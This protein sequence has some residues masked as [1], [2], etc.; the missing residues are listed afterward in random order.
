MRSNDYLREA[1]QWT[2][3]P[4]DCVAHAIRIAERLLEEGRAPWIGRVRD[5]QGQWHGPLIPR[6]FEGVTWTTHY[7]A[8]AGREVYDPIAGEPLDV[9]A[10]AVP[11]FG[12]PLI[13]ETHVGV[14]E[15]AQLLRAGTLQER[16]RV[17]RT[18]R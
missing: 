15:T 5:V 1:R 6:R 13:V 8:C 7:V 3:Y 16:F 18:A 10:Y 17:Y 2:T 4:E 9:D 11:V 14:E 12:K